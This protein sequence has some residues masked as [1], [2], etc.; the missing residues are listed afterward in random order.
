MDRS[1]ELRLAAL[2]VCQRVT[3]G[4]FWLT[5][6]DRSVGSVWFTVITKDSSTQTAQF[7]RDHA[8]PLPASLVRLRYE[9]A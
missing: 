9:Y 5:D 6:L 8:A 3:G 2:V 4:L 7:F 1:C